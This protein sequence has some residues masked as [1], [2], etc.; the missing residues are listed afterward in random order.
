MKKTVDA[1]PMDGAKLN[2][3]MERRH[4]SNAQLAAALPA[5]LRIRDYHVHAWRNGGD[6]DSIKLYHLSKFLRCR[7]ADLLPDDYRLEGV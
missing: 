1:L 2:A 4:L 7:M 5:S 6:I 3:R